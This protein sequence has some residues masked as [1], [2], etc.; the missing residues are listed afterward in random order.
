MLPAAPFCHS[1]YF[2][3]VP[4]VTHVMVVTSICFLKNKTLEF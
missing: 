1:F 4:V 3:M 2:H